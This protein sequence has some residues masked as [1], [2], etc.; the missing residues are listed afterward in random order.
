LIVTARVDR[1]IRK[2]AALAKID[3]TN[4]LRHHH[5]R[6]AVAPLNP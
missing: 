6:I 1:F 5:E 2:S 4:P 3:T